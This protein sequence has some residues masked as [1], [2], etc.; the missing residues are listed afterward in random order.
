MFGGWVSFFSHFLLEVRKLLTICLRCFDL[1]FLL[2][3]PWDQP[4]EESPEFLRYLRGEIFNE[5]P[6]DRLG[7]NALCKDHHPPP[8]FFTTHTYML[9]STHLWPP[10][11]RAR[12]T[13]EAP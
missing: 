13:N 10:D 5:E 4:T 2:D 6:W 1:V 3:T 11:C 7:E 12:E 9:S 8:F